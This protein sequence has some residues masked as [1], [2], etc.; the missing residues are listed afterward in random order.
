M[1]EV[2]ARKAFEP[3]KFVLGLL[4]MIPYGFGY[5]LRKTCRGLWWGFSTLRAAAVVGWIAGGKR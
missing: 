5:A 3:G 1:S 4:M 2:A